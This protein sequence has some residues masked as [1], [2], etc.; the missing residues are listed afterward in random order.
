MSLYAFLTDPVVLIVVGMVGVLCWLAA[1][2][3][4]WWRVG[5]RSG[6][7]WTRQYRADERLRAYLIAVGFG[8]LTWFVVGLWFFVNGGR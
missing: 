5:N 8:L 4:D 3:H 2:V 6:R 1:L 7:P